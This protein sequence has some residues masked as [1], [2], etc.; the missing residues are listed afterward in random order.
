MI[1]IQL[2]NN[3]QFTRLTD[4]IVN[5]TSVAVVSNT[6]DKSEIDQLKNDIKVLET[7][8]SSLQAHINT[9]FEAIMKK[10]NNK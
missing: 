2:Q 8:V 6:T 1:D 4:A 5:T 9:G 10:L 7:S 3:A